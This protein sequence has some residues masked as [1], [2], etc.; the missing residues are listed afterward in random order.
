MYSL[1]YKNTLKANKRT[2]RGRFELPRGKPHKISNLAPSQ[3]RLP[4]QKDCLI[5]LAH[6]VLSVFGLTW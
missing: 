5:L 6:V 4:Q 3:T 1:N 2:L